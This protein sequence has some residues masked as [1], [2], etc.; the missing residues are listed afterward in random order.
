MQT[1]EGKHGWISQLVLG[2]NY[3]GAPLAKVV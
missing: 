1:L 3:I 2:K